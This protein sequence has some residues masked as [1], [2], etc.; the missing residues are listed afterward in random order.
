MEGL[1]AY[2]IVMNKAEPHLRYC[3][4]STMLSDGDPI[5]EVIFK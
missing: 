5:Y 1:P 4:L 3:Y 2:C